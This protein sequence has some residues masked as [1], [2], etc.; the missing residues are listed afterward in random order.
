ML[1]PSILRVLGGF[2][3]LLSDPAERDPTLRPERGFPL[4]KGKSTFER[5]AVGRNCPWQ[6]GF[7]TS[8]FEAT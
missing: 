5:S 2:V 1:Q 4:E 8:A 7:A 3:A 6:G